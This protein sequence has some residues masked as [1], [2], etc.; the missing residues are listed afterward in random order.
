MENKKAQTFEFGTFWL[1]LVERKYYKKATQSIQGI[2]SIKIV[3]KMEN[4]NVYCYLST[5]CD[6]SDFETL[7]KINV[8]FFTKRLTC[9][10]RVSLF[11]YMECLLFIAFL[12]NFL[13]VFLK[14]IWIFLFFSS[15]FDDFFVAKCSYEWVNKEQLFH[16]YNCV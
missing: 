5:I 15:D 3:F 16:W 8:I 2:K 1:I 7:S 6:I 13:N 14:I 10:L 9:R 11:L 4:N 12:M